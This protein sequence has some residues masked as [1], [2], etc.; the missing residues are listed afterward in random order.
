MRQPRSEEL[1]AV[2][3][4]ASVAMGIIL[5]AALAWILTEQAQCQRAGTD[6]ATKS[7]WSEAKGCRVQRA[8]G[9]WVPLRRK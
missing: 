5:L 3:L 9:A 8:D 6:L 4:M 2:G 1:L 7:A